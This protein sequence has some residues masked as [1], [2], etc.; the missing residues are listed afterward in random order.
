MIQNAQSWYNVLLLPDGG[1]A[2]PLPGQEVVDCAS[3]TLRG[4]GTT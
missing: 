3:L 1:E 4:V 2:R